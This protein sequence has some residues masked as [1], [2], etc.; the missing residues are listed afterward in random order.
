M[1][2]VN[3]LALR[4]VYAA[5]LNVLDQIFGFSGEIDVV[6]EEKQEVPVWSMQQP[7]SKDPKNQK[8]GKLT[9]GDINILQTTDI[10]G[11]FPGHLLEPDFGADFGDFISFAH[12]LHNISNTTGVDLLLVDSGDRSDGNG[13]SDAS[14]PKNLYSSPVFQAGGYDL[15]TPGAT[16]L[17]N[18]TLLAAEADLAKALGD[19]YVSSNVDVAIT[20]KKPSPLGNQY[21]LWNTTNQQLRTLGLGFSSNTTAV[22][23]N[24]K[25]T[26]KGIDTVILE[27]W[28]QTLLN[29][30]INATVNA[31]DLIVVAGHLPVRGSAGF[32]QLL[33]AI[34]GV[35]PDIPV[36][37]LGGASHVRDF[38]VFDAHAV[39]LQSG[40]FLETVGFT[41]LNLTTSKYDRSYIDFNRPA[42]IS[43]SNVTEAEFD[44]PEGTTVSAEINTDREILALDTVISC[45]P[46]TYFVDRVP[47]DAPNSIYTILK[48]DVLPLLSNPLRIGLPTYITLGT[49][50]ITYDAVKG[51]WTIDSEYIVAPGT[52]VFLYIADLP[53]TVADSLLTVINTAP[54]ELGVSRFVEETVASNKT[55][56][57]PGYSTHDDLGS[58]GDDTPHKGWTF[59][60]LPRAIQA[61]KNVTV[62]AVTV[63]FVFDTA[64]SH[65]VFKGLVQLGVPWLIKPKLY[66]AEHVKDLIPQYLNTL[67]NT[68]IPTPE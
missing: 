14:D 21:R 51:N 64:L 54:S 25:V 37:F 50:A 60:P 4:A 63:D 3:L 49:D 43:H 59:Y 44:T 38:K 53:K 40:R 17:Y 35:N 12:H 67:P 47:V 34:R 6:S 27:P 8:H 45:V 56:T 61:E 42:L 32:S 13:L 15:V 68:C 19:A 7:S 31:L 26:V 33:A 9:W 10:H 55:Y 30:T 66:S 1:K 5:P 65:Y 41:S 24:T 29:E 39:G 23:K 58:S 22:L 28:F 46:E 52:N 48:D 62:G 20:S 11:W 57:T 36:F 18:K 16:E 2:V